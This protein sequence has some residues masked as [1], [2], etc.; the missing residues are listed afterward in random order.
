VSVAA[1]GLV[2]GQFAVSA[3]V[4]E[5]R[6]A[7]APAIALPDR[8]LA[9]LGAI[10]FCAFMLEGAG[11]QW[12]AVHMSSERGAGEALAAAGFEES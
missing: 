10:A 6:A 5:P 9:L 3:L 8:P 2:L 1:L 11:N 4:R 12:I 7:A